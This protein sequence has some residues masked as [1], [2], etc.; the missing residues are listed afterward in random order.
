MRLRFT[1]HS[2]PKVEWDVQSYSTCR[3]RHTFFHTKMI[4][5]DSALFLRA[6]TFQDMVSFYLFAHRLIVPMIVSLKF[7][8]PSSN[9]QIIL[10]WHLLAF[11]LQQWKCNDY[12]F[13]ISLQS[14]ETWMKADAQNIVD[15]F[16]SPS[17]QLLTGAPQD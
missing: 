15:C 13:P 11:F 8:L 17:S 12:L 1:T 4:S 5:N 9:Q 2:G 14:L 3:R 7:Y 16:G 10:K 6:Y